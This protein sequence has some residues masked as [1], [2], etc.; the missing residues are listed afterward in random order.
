VHSAD[1]LAEPSHQLSFA[2]Y[3]VALFPAQSNN[4]QCSQPVCDITQIC[5]MMLDE[6][7]GTPLERLAHVSSVQH[8]YGIVD[9]ARLGNS[10]SMQYWDYQKCTE[11]GFFHTCEKGSNCFYVQGLNSLEDPPSGN[12]PN[13]M[14]SQ[15]FGISWK[16][17]AAAVQRSNSFYGAAI[18]AATR[19]IW[20]NG[21]V[22]PWHGLS[23]LTSPGTEQPV[24]WPV[25]G[26]HH[27]A[28][29]SSSSESDQQSVKDARAS[30]YAQLSQWLDASE[31]YTLV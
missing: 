10:V 17:T 14:C 16:E 27:C 24:I 13:D 25:R 22:D 15:K 26:A 31:A 18:A 29:T 20:P 8:G 6:S 4:P 30:I 12:R 7:V 9:G 23:H 3:G 2:G 11:F 19:I 28:W 1:W 21:D 5:E